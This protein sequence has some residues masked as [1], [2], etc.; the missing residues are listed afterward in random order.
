MRAEVYETPHGIEKMIFLFFLI[1]Q[2]DYKYPGPVSSKFNQS[3]F[4]TSKLLN[5]WGLV[6]L[7]HRQSLLIINYF[8]LEIFRME[9]W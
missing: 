9:I 5:F 7:H 3:T 2:A 8:I 1:L 6:W 4:L